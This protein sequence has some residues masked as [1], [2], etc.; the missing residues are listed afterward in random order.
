MDQE[1]ELP[2]GVD[3]VVTKPPSMDR[4]HQVLAQVTLSK[5]GA[6]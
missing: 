6:A 4:L 2:D 3:A 5:T 1:G